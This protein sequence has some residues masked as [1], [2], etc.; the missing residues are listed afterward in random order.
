MKPKELVLII[1][2]YLGLFHL[3]RWLTADALRILCYHGFAFRDEAQFRPKLFMTPATFERRLALLARH[4]FPVLPLDEALRRLA[5]GSLPRGA[6]VIT[7][8]DGFYSVHALAAPLLEAYGFPATAYVSTYYVEHQAPIYRLAVQYLFW[9]A[10]RRT[11]R[12]DGYDWVADGSLDLHDA[13]ATTGVMWDIIRYGEERGDEAQR[14]RIARELAAALDVDLDWVLASRAL[15]LMTHEELRGLAARGVDVQ[16][17]TH[18]HRLAA[19]SEAAVRD[20]IE[21]NR[22]VLAQAVGAPPDHLCYPSGVW[23]AAQWPWL[24]RLGVKSA[25]TCLAGLNY[26]ATPVLGLR[27]FLDAENISAIAFEAELFGFLELSRRIRSRLR[28][29]RAEDVAVAAEM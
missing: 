17:H 18:R 27:R 2:K 3:A 6:T 21:T 20:E 14:G 1:A 10:P 13:A 15:S 23:A 24:E 19:D 29:Q 16:L 5:D 4:R 11:V 22:R 28:P 25:T 12:F 26:R 9:R 7:I 8:D